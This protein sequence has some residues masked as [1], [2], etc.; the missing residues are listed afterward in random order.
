M[1]ALLRRVQSDVITELYCCFTVLYAPLQ[2]ANAPKSLKVRS[3]C[4]R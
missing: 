1:D 4:A 2:Q 3:H